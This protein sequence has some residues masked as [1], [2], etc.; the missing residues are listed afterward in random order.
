[1]TR[2]V[3]IQP[4]VD[5]TVGVDGGRGDDVATEGLEVHA[6]AGLTGATTGGLNVHVGSADSHT[7]GAI[8]LVARAVEFAYERLE[9][10]DGIEVQDVEYFTGGNANV[11]LR[12]ATPPLV[13]LSLSLIGEMLTNGGVQGAMTSEAHSGVQE[14]VFGGRGLRVGAE[15][16][17]GP[18]GLGV[19]PSGGSKCSLR[20]GSMIW[21]LNALS[22]EWH[23][24]NTLAD[25]ERLGGH[26]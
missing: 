24:M 17:D 1:M 23:E 6:G 13:N 20:H 22:Q 8:N 15:G 26:Q 18:T 2:T 16:E 3:A 25:G 21:Y 10:V 14:A 19:P 11:V 5:G 12:V 9:G 7:G 4:G